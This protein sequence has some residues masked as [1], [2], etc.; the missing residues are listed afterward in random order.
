MN[1]KNF[2]TLIAGAAIA[3]AAGVAVQKAGAVPVT[4]V[5]TD[6]SRL[7]NIP[8]QTLSHELGEVNFFPANE[9]LTI[10]VSASTT[11]I[12]PDDGFLND[13]T[14]DILNN[15]SGIAWTNLFFV[16]DLGLTIGN[17]DGTVID[18]V[19]APGVAVDAFKIDGTVTVT[20][21]NDNL[22]GESG[23]VD[24]ILSPGESWRFTVT[25][26]HDPNFGTLPNPLFRNP[27]VFA[28]SEPYV[29]PAI[30]TANILAIPVPEPTSLAMVLL[31]GVMLLRRRPR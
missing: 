26:Y 5:Y 23:V 11:Y 30:S 28:G 2:S 19:N 4:G 9:A 18:V 3:A 15:V 24:E 10:N 8:N 6:D 25:N 21:L 12:V 29:V 1:R 17:A 31:A 16:A 14:V 22:Q 7:D 20:G 27:G 13:W